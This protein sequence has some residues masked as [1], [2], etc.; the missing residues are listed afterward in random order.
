[1]LLFP[2]GLPIPPKSQRAKQGRNKFCCWSDFSRLLDLFWNMDCCFSL[3]LGICR[4]QN[5]ACGPIPG[6]LAQAGIGWAFGPQ[7][8]KGKR[9]MR[10]DRNGQ[11]PINEFLSLEGWQAKPDG[12]VHGETQKPTLKILCRVGKECWNTWRTTPPR[13]APLPGGE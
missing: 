6:P 2:F 8:T 13:R 1:M 12:V 5:P 11:G 10:S 4:G 7:N 9:I 3:E